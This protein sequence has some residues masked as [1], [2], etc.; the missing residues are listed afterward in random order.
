MLRTVYLGWRVAILKNVIP[1][2][3]SEGGK[4]RSGGLEVKLHVS[5]IV[6]GCTVLGGAGNALRK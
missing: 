4:G 3:Q 6:I 2:G 1:I 5:A